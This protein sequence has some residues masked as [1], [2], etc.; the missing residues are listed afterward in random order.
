MGEGGKSFALSQIQITK[1]TVCLKFL[2][3]NS[4]RLSLRKWLDRDNTRQFNKP[5]AFF[6]IVPAVSRAAS[7]EAQPRA[8]GCALNQCLP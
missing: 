6:C 5:V 4:H 1:E 2:C 8:P 7:G 3:L